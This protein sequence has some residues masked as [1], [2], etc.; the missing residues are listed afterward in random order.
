MEQNMQSNYLPNRL[1]RRAPSLRTI[2]AIILLIFSNNG[3]CFS[4]SHITI[5]FN[6]IKNIYLNKNDSIFVI[7]KNR[8]ITDLKQHADPKSANNK[9]IATKIETMAKEKQDQLNALLIKSII[10]YTTQTQF[11][12]DTF[13]LVYKE[14]GNKDKKE[15]TTDNDIRIQYLGD[16]KYVAEYWE[17]GL[18]VN[19][20]AHALVWAHKLATSEYAKKHP[21]DGLGDVDKVK[22]NYADVRKSINDGK[23]ERYNKVMALLYTVEKDGSIIF[24]DPF[25]SVVDFVGR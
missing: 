21:N 5:N 6:Q 19:S 3:Y 17:D 15:I 13:M 23:Q 11:D 16:N 22:K 9:L 18:A 4:G 25:Q 10:D 24:H 20:E 7:I 2:F 12:V 14:L 1:Q 8:T